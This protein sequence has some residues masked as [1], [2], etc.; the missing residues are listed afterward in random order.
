VPLIREEKELRLFAP[1]AMERA[2]GDGA[3]SARFSDFDKAGTASLRIQSGLREGTRI[4]I[5]R[6]WRVRKPFRAVLKREVARDIKHLTTAKA[7]ATRT[8]EF[9]HEKPIVFAGGTTPAVEERKQGSL[10]KPVLANL[11]RGGNGSWA[12]KRVVAFPGH[13]RGTNFEERDFW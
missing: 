1:N 2:T 9:N 13:G 10:P 12:G 5:V 3:I 11:D 8:L 7:F 6:P 4:F